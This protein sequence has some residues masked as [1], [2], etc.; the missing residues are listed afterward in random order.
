[1]LVIGRHE[2]L[3]ADVGRFAELA[4]ASGVFRLEPESQAKG[5]GAR[6]P[7][8]EA[9][10]RRTRYKAGS[11]PPR[12]L[13]IPFETLEHPGDLKIRAFGETLAEAF[14]N[15]GRAMMAFLFGDGI[16]ETTP[17]RTE[18]IAVAADDRESLLVD[19]LSELLWQ[20]STHHAAYVP[21]RVTEIT[22]T[23]LAAEVGLTPAR[24]I[25]DIKGV[26]YHELSIGRAHERWEVTV[27]CDL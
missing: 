20:S 8:M 10:V 15:V 27:V 6:A 13:M 3:P 19:W 18:L 2:R 11:Q 9:P 26:T 23:R 4:R 12:T 22:G 16:L 5:G 14:A 24:A 25:E 17:E 1:V 21:L 7:G